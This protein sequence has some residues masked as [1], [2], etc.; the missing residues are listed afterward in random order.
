MKQGL[1]RRGFLGGISA[2]VPSVLL[3]APR[4]RHSRPPNIVFI[5][6]DDLGYADLGCYG[7]KDIQTPHIDRLAAEGIRF[8]N[9]YA[10][11]ALCAPSRCSLL[12]GL[13]T[14]HTPIKGNNLALMGPQAVTF[15]R[16]LRDMGY[17]TGCIGK[18]GVGHPPPPG[19]PRV[20]GFDYFFGYLSMWHAHNYY[21]EFLWRNEEKVP[22]RNVVKHP[23]KYYMA[24]Q[25]GLVGIATK[26][27]DYAPDLFAREALQ[28]IE[29]NREKPFFLYFSTIV[30]H[31]NDE[32]LNQPDGGMEV[33]DYGI[34][35][36]KDWTQDRKGYAAM[37]TRMDRDIGRLMT[38]LKELGL[39]RDTMV[40]FASDNGAGA[41]CK[42]NR[43]CFAGNGPFRGWKDQLYEG[44]IRVPLIARWPGKIPAA[45][46][47]DQ[48]WA[49][50]DMMPT[51]LDMTGGKTP[52]RIDGLS[53][54]PTLMG[55]AGRQKQHDYLYWELEQPHAVQFAARQGNW[56]GVKKG[57]NKPLEI[58]DLSRDPGE[59][60]DL[61]ADNPAMVRQIEKVIQE[62]R[63]PH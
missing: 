43:P 33:P 7:Q 37:I 61:A 27:V 53:F 10:G 18:W 1:S 52:E 39:D 23:K 2:L 9:H 56:K 42:M 12:M 11:D 45:R 35:A 40:F 30:P 3:P 4:P 17:A 47:S 48:V 25:V 59:T 8:R 50:W 49:F 22:L 31:A 20:H 44:G 14:G 62:A 6:S 15:P 46:V 58:Y 41:D 19:D 13:H 24:D 29:K 55:D 51:L 5:L 26:R 32:A 63:Q 34:Y 60:T 16:I 36:G 57:V 28:F 21:P 38:R 54:A